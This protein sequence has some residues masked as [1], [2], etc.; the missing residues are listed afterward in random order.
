M[1]LLDPVPGI[2]VEKQM[3]L[4]EDQALNLSSV[5]SKPLAL[6]AAMDMRMR[7]YAILGFANFSY[8]SVLFKSEAFL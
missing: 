4:E 8:S 3:V 6:S 7:R 1:K 5:C 2:H